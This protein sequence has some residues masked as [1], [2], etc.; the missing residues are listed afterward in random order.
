MTSLKPPGTA[1]PEIRNRRMRPWEWF[2]VAALNILATITTLLVVVAWFLPVEVFQ[3]WAFE[4]AT[5]DSYRRFEAV[6]QAEAICWVVR[7]LGPFV[8]FGTIRLIRNRESTKESLHRIWQGFLTA[9][10]VFGASNTDPANSWPVAEQSRLT[11]N[12]VRTWCLRGMVLLWMTFAVVQFGLSA[13]RRIEEWPYY[14]F[15]SGGVVLPNISESNRE[16][17]WY[18]RERTPPNSRILVVSDQKLYFLAYYLRP[19]GVYHRVHPDSAFVIAKPHQERW[20]PAYHLEELDPDWICQLRPDFV[21]EYFEHPD[22]FDTSKKLDD[23]HWIQFLRRMRDDPNYVPPYL[24]HLRPYQ[25]NC[26]Q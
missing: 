7:I 15:R 8:V 12:R 23:G 13:N 2:A 20:M 19:R 9:T 6:G 17:I 18:L 21:L 14:K 11:V 26:T 4:F 16:V 10:Q 25:E 3:N 24:I 5:E 22:N 1:M